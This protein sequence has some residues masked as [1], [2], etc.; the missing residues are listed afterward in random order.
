MG[1]PKQL[2]PVNGTPAIRYC[3]A[4]VLAAGLSDI[5]VVIGARGTQ[6][7]A[8]IADLPVRIVH[9]DRPEGEMVESVRLGLRQAPTGASS[10]LLCLADHPLVRPATIRTLL[11]H[12]EDAPGSIII[13]RHQ[14]RRGH[15]CVFPR[16]LIEE[17]FTGK[18]LREVI[19]QHADHIRFVNV[20]DEGVVLD[21][22][23]PEDYDAVVRKKEQDP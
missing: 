23:T 8:V 2:L 7:E 3:L 19:Q 6:I 15:P 12:H 22:D 5:I 13:P 10:I 14:G 17:V 1:R 21:M 11:R 9:N 20:D 16:S 18:T 4:S